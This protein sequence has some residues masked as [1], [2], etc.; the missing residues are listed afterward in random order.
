MSKAKVKKQKRRKKFRFTLNVAYHIICGLLIVAGILC[1]IFRFPNVFM[2]TLLAFKDLG[3][4]I[5]YYFTELFG[6]YGVITPTVTQIPPDAVEVLPFDV[7]EFQQALAAFGLALIS[8]D[9]VARFFAELADGLLTASRIIMPLSMLLFLMGLLI[10]FFYTSKN[11]QFRADKPLPDSKPLRIFKRVEAVTWLPTKL[12]FRRFYEFLSAHRWYIIGWAVLWAYNLNLLTIA[13]EALSYLLYLCISFDFINLYVQVAKLA[14]DLTVIVDY[15]H[16]P[17]WCV[18]GYVVFDK[19]R[20]NLGFSFLRHYEDVNR[21]FLDEHPGALFLVGKQ[22]AK[23][24]TI[25]TDMALSQEVIFRTEAKER[26]FERRRQF[27][28]FPWRNLE[29]VYLTGR[30]KKTLPTLAKCRKLIRF[31]RE[32]YEKNPAPA[33]RRAVLKHL[34]K[35]YGYVWPDFLF[36]YDAARYGMEHNDGL[37][38]INLF[39]ALEGY[40]QLFYIYGAPTSLMV[41]NYAIRGDELYDEEDCF[42]ELDDDFF[43]RKPEEVA[44]R[45]NYS[46]ILDWDTLRLGKVFE[47]D[48]PNKDG[49]EFGIAVETEIAKERG[50]QNTN[51]G[52]KADA[53]ECN[54]KNDL[55]EINMKME[56][57]SATIDNYTFFRLLMDDQRPDSLSADNKDLC[58]VILIKGVTSAKIVMPGFAIEEALYLIQKSVFDKVYFRLL[59]LGRDNTLLAYLLKKIDNLFHRHYKGVYN[60]F[61][62]YTANLKVWDAM[63]DEVLDD[64]GK[65]YISTKKTYSGRFA[66]DA[67]KEFYNAKALRSK[68]GLNEFETFGNI[69]MTVEEMDKTHSLF[70]SK[71]NKIF[72]SGRVR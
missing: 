66:T 56:G 18:I 20:R 17:T 72:R 33:Q 4:S 32:N 38:I 55:V 19:L 59:V 37:S 24:T 41:S 10:Y 62:V 8:G 44:E 11:E 49:F 64:K 26:L 16:V 23:K 31:I 36:G 43:K 54:Q 69:R 3:L 14:M 48:N 40:I 47:Q 42:P 25:I 13:V 7:V 6:F 29:L 68:R 35:A 58:D 71:L 67:I 60:Q 70:Y 57:H 39:D 9:N 45:S 5:A 65:Y 34:K 52:T 53:A 61:S 1:A 15:L 12:F 2:R 51:Q 28:N 30:D 22:R 21:T 50:N 27:P 63:Q 46:H